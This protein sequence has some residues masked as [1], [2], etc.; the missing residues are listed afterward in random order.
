MTAPLREVLAD[1]ERAPDCPLRLADTPLAEALLPEL[2]FA[3]LLF[4]EVALEEATGVR[5]FTF[6]GEG[7]DALRSALTKSS[8]FMACQPETP[9]RFAI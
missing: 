1:A 3:E 4:A 8:F 5:D 6:A 9:R 2:L 7:L